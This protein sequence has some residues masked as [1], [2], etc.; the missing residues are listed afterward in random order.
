MRTITATLLLALAACTSTPPD[1]AV[2]PTPRTVRIVDGTGQVTQL[3]TQSEAAA[4]AVLVEVPADR[5]WPALGAAYDALGIPKSTIDSRARL[6]GANVRLR[7]RLG[8]ARLSTYLDCGRA[9]GGPS[10]DTYDIHLLVETRIVERELET[11][12]VSTLVEAT[13]RPTGFAQN[14]VRCTTTGT[15]ERRIIEELRAHA[16]ASAEG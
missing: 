7:S 5:A 11:S 3:A 6:L 14:P 4:S 10:A 13:A 16:R 1:T 9:Q 8:N 15:L 12:R 2:T